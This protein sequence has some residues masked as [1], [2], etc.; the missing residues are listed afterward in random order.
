[1]LYL[2]WIIILYARRTL[3]YPISGGIEM[4]LKRTLSLILTLV[5]LAAL[6]PTAAFADDTS[7]LSSKY[8]TVNAGEGVSVWNTDISNGGVT[9]NRII[10]HASDDAVYDAVFPEDAG[11]AAALAYC[12]ES[13]EYMTA[14]YIKPD[15][16]GNDGMLVWVYVRS[17]SVELK[18]VSSLRNAD[19][20]AIKP[21]REDSSPLDY[22]FLKTDQAADTLI[23]DKCSLTNVT[24]VLFG[25]DG[26]EIRR[27]I[28]GDGHDYDTYRFSNV[29]VCVDSYADGAKTGTGSLPV[30]FA[31]AIGLEPYFG[32]KVVIPASEDL[33]R[34]GTVKVTNGS[35]I[36]AAPRIKARDAA[37]LISWSLEQSTTVFI[38]DIDH[39]KE[40][41][42]RLLSTPPYTAYLKIAEGV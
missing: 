23:S 7:T 4:K 2:F 1:M 41:G 36:Y 8:V 15:K 3:A 5:M 32:A 13:F 22:T 39:T 9:S 14:D 31:A 42:A 19:G 24:L 6:A 16:D 40:D 25:T 17:G 34:V 33:R 38:D 21:Y 26:A 35:G 28:D 12:S 11:T 10:V 30:S 27:V 18:V 37:N 29:L 20:S